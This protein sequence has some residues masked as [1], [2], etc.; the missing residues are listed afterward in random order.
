M[1][2][3][4]P[5]QVVYHYFTLSHPQ[6]LVIDLD[7]TRFPYQSANETSGCGLVESLHWAERKHQVLRYVLNLTGKEPVQLASSPQSHAPGFR[8]LVRIGTLQKSTIGNDHAEPAKA[9]S[10][11][12]NQPFLQVNPGKGNIVIAID[13]GHGGSDPGTHGPHGLD[14]KVVTL[15]IAKMLAQKIDKTPGL[16]AFLTRLSDHYV[17]LRQR[18]LEAQDHHAALFIS[19]HANAY[20]RVPRVK[21]GAVYALSEHGASNAEA[22]LLARTENA[23][24]PTIGNIKFA[25]HNREVNSALS[26]MLQRASIANGTDLGTDVLRNLSHYEP[27]Y[28]HHVQYANFEVLRDPLIPSIL[29]ETAFLSNPYQARE[30]HEQHFREELANAIYLGIREFLAHHDLRPTQVVRSQRPQTSATNHSQPPESNRTVTA[31]TGYRVRPGDTLSGVAL[32]LHV[33]VWRLDVYNHLHSKHLHI[34]Q[35]LKLPPPSF[36]YRV[37]NGDSL[38]VIAEKAGVSSRALKDYNNLDNNRLEIGQL[39]TVPPPTR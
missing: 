38:S 16:T 31:D 28:E 34:G 30:L 33:N 18:V 4:L 9:V 17:G 15:S 26:H 14:E 6:R 37:R 7:S 22:R 19:I 36:E 8:L 11:R 5:A 32:R 25:T 3:T 29:I 10:R 1:Q 12:A 23:A 24:D 39:L 27:L 35:V 21:G 2:L 20:P 13:P